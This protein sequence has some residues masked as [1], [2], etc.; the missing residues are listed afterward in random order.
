MEAETCAQIGGLYI[1]EGQVWWI[2]LLSPELR[3]WVMLCGGSLHPQ[4]RTSPDSCPVSSAVLSSATVE[5]SS[6][7]VCDYPAWQC[8][9]EMN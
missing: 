7:S 8:W 4:R 3:L 9:V 1:A 2:T 5:D 6:S